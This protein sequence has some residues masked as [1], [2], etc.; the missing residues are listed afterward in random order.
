MGGATGGSMN[1]GNVQQTGTYRKGNC[2]DLPAF[3]AKTLGWQPTCTCDAGTK[4]GVVLDPFAG[5]GTTLM[6]ARKHRRHGIGLDLNF[7]YLTTNA[8]ERLTYGDF[9][10]VADGITQLTI[11][12]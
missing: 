1:T 10:P 2:A 5:S 7:E 3:E 6:V 4:P 11:G 12:A 8:R 9:V